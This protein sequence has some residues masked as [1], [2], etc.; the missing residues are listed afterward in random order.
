MSL[1]MDALKKAEAAKRQSGEGGASDPF[2]ASA[3]PELTLEPVAVPTPPA[4]TAPSSGLP[5]L[6]QHIDSVDADLAAVSTTAPAKKRPPQP[7]PKPADTSTNNKDAEERNA[8][9]NVFAVKQPPK[10]RAPL[11]LLLGFA[12][13]ATGGIGGYFWWQL[14]SVSGSSLARPP[15]LAQPP[16]SAPIQPAPAAA[17]LSV[18]EARKLEPA[19]PALP[20]ESVKP[21]LPE[22]ALTPE[23]RERPRAETAPAAPPADADRPI[24]LSSSRLKQDPTLTRAYESLLAD[25]LSDAQQDYEQV[26]RVDPKN[27]DA[28][29]GLATIAARQGQ[30]DKAANLYL[31]V[32]EADPKDVTAKAGLINLKGQSDPALS[33]SRLKTL[34]ANQ[35]DSAALNFALGNLQARQT[36]WGDAQQAY[37]RA[38]TAEP[39]NADYLFNLAVSLDHLRQ[40]KLAVQYYQMALTAAKTR[41]TAFDTNQVKNRLLELQP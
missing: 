33:E 9:R 2:A 1:L 19:M 7:A 26:L 30:G 17:S 32:L 11:W 14:Q 34:L 20:L 4:A 22:A 25:K 5:N 35:P 16:V 29:L 28:L 40:N 27:T 15:M 6:S 37:F 13:L 18:A 12:V 10:S 8:A 24:R 36:R 23:R 31:R 3:A 41:T 21:P 38:Y 39:D